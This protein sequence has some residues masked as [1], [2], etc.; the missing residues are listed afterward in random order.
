MG[1][2][3]IKKNNRVQPDKKRSQADK[4][5]IGEERKILLFVVKEELSYMEQSVAASKRQSIVDNTG[6]ITDKIFFLDSEE[7]NAFDVN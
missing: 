5:E 3:L 7:P 1:C 6:K 2:V 4:D